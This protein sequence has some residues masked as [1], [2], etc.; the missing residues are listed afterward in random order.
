MNNKW[1]E[2][3]DKEF[4][5]NLWQEQKPLPGMVSCGNVVKAF[6][7]DQITKA[8][9]EIAESIIEDIP[10]FYIPTDKLGKPFGK[11]FKDQLRKKY[12]K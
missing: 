5:T 10:D 2:E 9:Q 4:V 1:E 3:F 12:I 11:Y 8:Q 6:I 7:K